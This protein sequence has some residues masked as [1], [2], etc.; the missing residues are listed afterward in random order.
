MFWSIPKGAIPTIAALNQ[1][2]FLIYRAANEI[3]HDSLY[4]Y[5]TID[6]SNDMVEL[7][8]SLRRGGEETTDY[9]PDTPPPEAVKGVYFKRYLPMSDQVRNGR[10][11]WGEGVA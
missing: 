9:T 3:W 4:E 8:S 10:R 5:M 11:S 7:A 2:V 1:I 6:V